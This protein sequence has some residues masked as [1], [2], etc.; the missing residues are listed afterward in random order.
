ML[1]APVNLSLLYDPPTTGIGWSVALS[2][3]GWCLVGLACW[4]WRRTQPGLAFAVLC[5]FWLLLPVLN[6]FPITTL[7]NDRYLYLPCVC[8]FALA[9]LGVVRFVEWGGIRIE[10][11]PE[12]SRSWRG[13]AARSLVST[14]VA[15]LISGFALASIGRLPV[16]KDDLALWRR[17]V[18]QVPQLAV[19][20]IQWADALHAYGRQPAAVAALHV[21]LSRCDPDPA[22]RERI[23]KRLI[24]WTVSASPEHARLVSVPAVTSR[25]LDQP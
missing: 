20:Q 21:A 23:Q 15:A 9:S 3:A 6:L 22:D 13:I 25:E 24:E 14:A 8:A 4:R 10:A 11:A 1:I 18:A 19:V 16:W 17:T 2:I 5:W 7:M 12:S